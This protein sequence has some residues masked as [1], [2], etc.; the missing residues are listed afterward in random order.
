MPLQPLAVTL[1]IPGV[2]SRAGDGE[3]GAFPRLPRAAAPCGG[4]WSP[5]H[6]HLPQV[7]SRA[8]D[9]AA[10][11]ETGIHCEPLWLTAAALTN[12][13]CWPA[14]MVTSYGSRSQPQWFFAK[15]VTNTYCWSAIMVMAVEVSRNGSSLQ[16]YHYARDNDV[17]VFVKMYCVVS[18]LFLILPPSL[19]LSRSL[20]LPAIWNP[21]GIICGSAVPSTGSS[22]H[23]R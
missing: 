22:Q 6:A 5:F 12:A 23:S 14:I 2:H 3:V 16:L 10:Y 11:S 15:A 7:H 17:I 21:V 4:V 18:H 20:S 9:S 19:P 13:Y 8:G 1:F